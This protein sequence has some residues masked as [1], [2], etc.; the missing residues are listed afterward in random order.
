MADKLLHSMSCFS[1]LINKILEQCM[2]RNIVEVGSEYAGSTKILA[3]YAAS[4]KATL[5]VIDPAPKAD[6]D[7]ILADFKGA[8]QF[9]REKSLDVLPKL[10]ADIYFLDG[11]HNYWTVFNELKSIYS[12]N[13]N[14]WVVLHDVGFPCARRDMYYN[15]FS[16][17]KE[18][19]HEFSYDHGVNLEKGSVQYRS[20]FWGAG[21]YAIALSSDTPRN[22][23]LTAI[24]DFMQNRGE[25][26]YE[27]I[28][29]IFGLGVITP[30]TNRDFIQRILQPYQGELCHI[31]ETNRLD[32]YN[33]VLRLNRFVPRTFVRRWLNRILDLLGL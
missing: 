33:E 22:G 4:N 11:D 7:L 15:P 16:I 17:P 13:P 1:E 21:H 2:P 19:L 31:L 28:P 12:I 25:L 29:L 10:N 5:H 30:K 20:G 18:G 32:L 9:I 27:S 26:H 23:V 24:E 14:A 3:A 6:P 8:Y